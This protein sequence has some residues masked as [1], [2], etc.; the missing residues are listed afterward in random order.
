MLYGVDLHS[1]LLIVAQ[2]PENAS[3]SQRCKISRYERSEFKVFF[4][5]LKPGDT[6][7]V[8]CLT[9]VWWFIEQVEKCGSRPVVVNNYKFRI[10]CDS[11]A[12]TD[13]K[14][15]EKICRFLLLDLLP[16][17]WI[18]P[19]PIRHA[20][21]IVSHLEFLRKHQ[22]A[23]KNRIR[24]MLLYRGIQFNSALLK[25][26]IGKQ[27]LLEL[28]NTVDPNA[29]M[30]LMGLIEDCETL[31]T[32]RD[33]LEKTLI[34]IVHEYMSDEFS[35]ALS[36]TGVS[37]YTAA[38]VL[39]QIGDITRFDDHKKLISYFGLNPTIHQSN[40]MKHVGHISR[41]GSHSARSVLSQ[42]A[43]NA[44]RY[45]PTLRDSYLRIK[46]RRGHGRAMVAIMLRLTKRLFYILKRNEPANECKE[47]LYLTKLKQLEK[48]KAA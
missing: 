40:K 28:V 14:D 39:A 47:K 7:A 24:S 26:A 36:I 42:A 12:K 20:R 35:N 17:V 25:S 6:V 44:I 16:Q 27:R 37:A 23:I 15:A 18:P 11:A 4:S 43:L 21:E 29:Y 30:M 5:L 19:K 48:L 33:R 13:K 38:V 9:N 31:A 45:T 1:S 22:Q 10:I 41:Q 46:E 3:V 2:L 34:K 8:E 32:R